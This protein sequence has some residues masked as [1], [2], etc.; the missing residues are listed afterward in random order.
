MKCSD[1]KAW[2][3]TFDAIDDWICIIDL[4]ARILRSNL[5]AEKLF[6]MKIQDIVG[7]KCCTL[8]HGSD[9][10]VQDC[11]LPK[12]IETG[13]R[14][15]CELQLKDGPWVYVTVDPLVDDHGKLTGAVHIARDITQRIE[16]Q[17]E[18]ERLIGDLENALAQ[19]KR[20]SGLIPICGNCKKS[21]MTKGIGIRLMP[22]LRIIQ[23]PNSAMASARTAQTPCTR[24]RTGTR[25]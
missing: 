24:I 21:G 22:I 1:K 18:R 8:A 23:R 17:N 14:A 2:E 16:Y 15:I 7:Q 5:V 3:K 13:K 12:M 25:I 11:P 4:D 10:P 19:V 6:Q 9:T 20:L